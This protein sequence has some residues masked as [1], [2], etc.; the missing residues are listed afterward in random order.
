[1]ML[2]WRGFILRRVTKYILSGLSSLDFL[3]LMY[4]FELCDILL[5][6]MPVFTTR[7]DTQV[8]NSRWYLLFVCIEF[9]VCE[10]SLGPQEKA[11]KVRNKQTHEGPFSTTMWV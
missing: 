9:V 2:N 8:L 10:V 6:T 3:P 1:M 5:C 11:G 4:E 7:S